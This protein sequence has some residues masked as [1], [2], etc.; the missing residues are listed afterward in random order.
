VPSLSSQYVIAVY[1]R[2]DE[3]V[4]AALA[5]I[6]EEDRGAPR[7]ADEDEVFSVSVIKGSRAKVRIWRWSAP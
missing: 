3:G 6:T 7:V 4:D 1:R 5:E 2:G